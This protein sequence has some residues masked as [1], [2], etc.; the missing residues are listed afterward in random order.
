MLA[1]AIDPDMPGYVTVTNGPESFGAIFSREY[2]ETRNIAGV[3][4]VIT[5]ADA[6][7]PAVGDVLTINA[8]NYTAQEIQPMNGGVTKVLLS[9]G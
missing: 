1:E 4:P 6:N 9:N 5:V 8:T 7:A 2:I 3:E